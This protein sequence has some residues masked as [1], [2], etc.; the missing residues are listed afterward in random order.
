[1]K[2]LYVPL[3]GTDLST[4]GL[5]KALC[6]RHEVR[7]YWDDWTNKYDDVIYFQS[8]AISKQDLQAL[9]IFHPSKVVQ[10]TGD[11]RPFPLEMV[12]QYRGLTNIDFMAADVPEI[13]PDMNIKWLPHGVDDWQFREVQENTKGVVMIARN[14][15]HL[16]G[17]QD[18]VKLIDYLGDKLAVFGFENHLDYYL[19]PDVYSNFK[20]AIGPSVYND[21]KYY[22]GNRPLNAMA[23]G[24]CFI[25]KYFPGLEDLFSPGINCLVYNEVKDLD[26]LLKISDKVRCKIARAGQ[27]LVYEKYHYDN[28]VK[29]FENQIKKL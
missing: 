3:K 15:E 23:A 22:F 24:C 4:D 17:G 7:C 5:Y 26:D 10:W 20:F 1:M 28:I 11:Y 12:T 25:F 6:K 21:A 19:A 13:Y 14:Y 29:M 27:D 2:I 9:A 8:G 18:R 16:P